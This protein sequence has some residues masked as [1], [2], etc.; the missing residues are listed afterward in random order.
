ML[1]R[2]VFVY[3]PA[4]ILV[5]GLAA[6]CVFCAFPL[7]RVGEAFGG[8][9]GYFQGYSEAAILLAL[10]LWYLAGVGVAWLVTVKATG[11]WT[12]W[13]RPLAGSVT[14][15]ALVGWSFADLLGAGLSGSHSS[16]GVGVWPFRALSDAL[17]PATRPLRRAHYLAHLDDADPSVRE[18]A[19]SGTY[20]ET[21][22]DAKG[23]ARFQVGMAR[24]LKSD[25]PKVVHELHQGLAECYPLAPAALAEVVA[26]LA[27]SP[28]A[29]RVEVA[30][31]LG[32]LG[33]Y[34]HNT[35]EVVD[36]L[37]I[38]TNDSAQPVR[39]AA[40]SALLRF[41]REDLRLR[42]LLEARAAGDD[43]LAATTL[44]EF[45]GGERPAAEAFRRGL[46]SE[47]PTRR[48]AWTEAL[49]SPNFKAGLLDGNEVL[50][51]ALR[52]ADAGVRLAATLVLG[53]GKGATTCRAQLALVSMLR[54]PSSEVRQAAVR[55]LHRVD[56]DRRGEPP[57]EV[58]LALVQAL[59][60][61]ELRSLAARALE[62]LRP[63]NHAVLSAVV[64]ALGS[65]N[66]DGAWALT[67]LLREVDEPS[68][69]PDIAGLLSSQSDQV[70]KAALEILDDK[71]LAHPAVERALLAALADEREPDTTAEGATHLL[72]KRRPAPS[73][74]RAALERIAA[75]A[76]GSKAAA[77]ARRVL[78]AEGQSDPQ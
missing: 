46:A 68:I 1:W 11:A 17:M 55:G 4:A 71:P 65:G 12:A 6:F 66:R 7:S 25:D 75:D 9:P 5:A 42:H 52:D 18:R 63:H 36:A 43:P 26:R 58:A 44:L 16:G 76:P 37:L 23:D 47:D 27:D 35:P 69:L 48:R 34:G 59:S 72:A 54:D 41:D 49:G 20:L 56:Y 57:P 15:L 50:E 21:R 78:E 14:A 10:P 60:D 67:E 45:P 64:A 77:R 2:V 70:R 3:S 39:E 32:T 29:A 22:D 8:Q 51:R 24:A 40:V 73:A 28:A 61:P 30:E 74:T 33:S 31:L 62:S 53:S 19:A 13:A 38:A